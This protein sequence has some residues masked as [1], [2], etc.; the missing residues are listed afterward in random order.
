M[1]AKMLNTVLGLVQVTTEQRNE[2]K[3]M[4][5][6][7]NT[8]HAKNEDLL[9]LQSD[10]LRVNVNSYVIIYPNDNGWKKIIKVIAET[11][12]ICSNDAKVM[13]D[14]KRTPDNGYKDQLWCIMSELNSMYYNE[15]RFFENSFMLME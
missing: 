6:E 1:S 9:R 15:Q 13:V 14:K 3:D 10:R 8:A 12:K 4:K 5:C 2:I 11:H 7:L